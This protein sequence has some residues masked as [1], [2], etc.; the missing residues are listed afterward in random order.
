MDRAWWK[1]SPAPALYVR[2]QSADFEWELNDAGRQWARD[3]AVSADTL[4][5]VACD[6]GHRSATAAA[7]AVGRRRSTPD[8]AHCA[9]IPCPGPMVGWPGA[10]RTS[11]TPPRPRI[12]WSAWISCGSRGESAWLF[13]TC[14]PVKAGG[15]ATR[16]ACGASTPRGAL[17]T[18]AMPS[19]AS[20]PTTVPG[21]WS[22]WRRGPTRPASRMSAF[23]WNGPMAWCGTCTRWCS[24][25][26]G[27]TVICARCWASSST[28]PRRSELPRAARSRRGGPPC[29][30]AG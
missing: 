23:G 22:A 17:P 10:C 24:S 21:C 26:P 30:G 1:A 5:R 13:A 20:T 27:P 8:A 12:C 28:T 29:A 19:S 11:C 14:A 16:S 15:I 3:G 18:S 6:V 9:G 4:G 7:G 25:F 2:P